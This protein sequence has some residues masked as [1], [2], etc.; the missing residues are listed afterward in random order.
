MNKYQYGSREA[1]STDDLLTN[2]GD[3]DND[4]DSE[5]V[6]SEG[7]TIN[8]RSTAGFMVLLFAL[9]T[10][11]TLMSTGY[12]H[13]SSPVIE[14]YS[15][16][17]DESVVHVS[18]S[19]TPD[20]RDET[21]TYASNP[22]LIPDSSTYCSEVEVIVD[23]CV[24]DDSIIADGFSCGDVTELALNSYCDANYTIS[25]KIE[26]EIISYLVNITSGNVTDDEYCDEIDVVLSDCWD[27]TYICSYIL[28]ELSSELSSYINCTISDDI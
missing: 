10:V 14:G 11:G 1:H 6:V 16:E 8:R 24:D 2:Y 26:E 17:R 28:D 23:S 21:V 5:E 3:D 4:D 27:S 13:A 12:T 9:A 22:V 15:D 20:M 7:F 25:T 19:E 18:N